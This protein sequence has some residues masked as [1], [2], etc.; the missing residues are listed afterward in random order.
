MDDLKMMPDAE[1]TALRTELVAS[2]GESADFTPGTFQAE[3]PRCGKPNCHCATPGDPGH[4]PRFTVMR[5]ESGRTVKRTVPAR[6]A[7]TVRERVSR[8]DVF[9]SLVDR[10]ADINAEISRRLL[11]GEHVSKSGSSPVGGEKGGCSTK[12]V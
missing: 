11:I 9:K 5:Y 8:W 3:R 12:P 1:L 6:L 2:L 10:I 4:S 7:E